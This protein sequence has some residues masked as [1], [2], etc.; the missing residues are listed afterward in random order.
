ML[1]QVRE[2]KRKKKDLK[3]T[4]G[5]WTNGPKDATAVAFH[6]GICDFFFFLVIMASCQCF[7]QQVAE[8]S[9][10]KDFEALTG[11]LCLSTHSERLYKEAKTER[12]RRVFR[13]GRE[14]RRYKQMNKWAKWG[15][16]NLRFHPLP[17]PTPSLLQS[18]RQVCAVSARPPLAS[19]SAPLTRSTSPNRN[20]SV[21]L[22]M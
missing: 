1:V 19:A 17:A 4:S 6:S 7:G 10:V 16:G 22:N 12:Q 15:E 5:Y 18:D 20:C 13:T 8:S 2:P 14:E 9:E 21:A 3:K 11:N